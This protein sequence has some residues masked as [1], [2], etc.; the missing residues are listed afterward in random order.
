MPDKKINQYD[1]E[2]N[3]QYGY[4]EQRYTDSDRIGGIGYYLNN[5]RSG[6]WVFYNDTKKNDIM[7]ERYYAK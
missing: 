7:L 3:Q 4:W 5:L 2:V 1:K 6:Y